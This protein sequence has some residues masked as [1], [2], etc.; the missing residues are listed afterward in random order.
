VVEAEFKG[1][2]WLEDIPI[3]E[4]DPDPGKPF[5]IELS[6]LIGPKDAPGEELFLVD[7]SNALFLRQEAAHSGPRLVVS[8]IL[9]E[10]FRVDAVERIVR[11]FCAGCR[12]E[13]WHEVALK[14]TRL[15]RW[16]YEGLV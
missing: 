11:S 6:V 1:I 2:T 7:V 16:E 8:T 15:G 10:R 12:G 14:L 3:E 4:Y 13:S 5:S 9:V